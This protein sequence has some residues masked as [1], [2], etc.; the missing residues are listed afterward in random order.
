MHKTSSKHDDDQGP[1][2]SSIFLDGILLNTV[3]TDGDD[4]RNDDRDTG[5]S[6]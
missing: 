1:L 4:A 5:G 2:S 6:E 3:A